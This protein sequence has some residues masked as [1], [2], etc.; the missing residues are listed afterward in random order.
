M[1]Y[2]W[3]LPP[4]QQSFFQ[5]WCLWVLQL[6]SIGWQERFL[7]TQKT[8]QALARE[9]MPRSIFGQMKEWNVY[10]EPT[11]MTLKILCHSLALAFCIPWVVQ[12]SLRPSCT[13]DSLLARESTTRLRI[14]HPFPSQ[15]V[16]WLF[17][18]D[19][20]LHFQWLTGYWRV[21]CTCKENHTTYHPVIF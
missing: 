13:S 10:E 8:A 16:V 11:W 6:H 21:G 9:K 19:M 1:K 14:W 4:M 17:S 3:P 12:I 2:S 7:P 5:K 18:L 15:I 20:E